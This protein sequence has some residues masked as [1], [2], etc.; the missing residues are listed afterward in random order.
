MQRRRDV[1]HVAV[2]Q[3]ID[4]QLFFFC[5]ENRVKINEFSDFLILFVIISCNYE[6][7]G[8]YLKQEV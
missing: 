5:L 7:R 4:F 3:I 1:G 8:T 6:I 2:F